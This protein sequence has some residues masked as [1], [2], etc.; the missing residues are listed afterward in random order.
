VSWTLIELPRAEGEGV[1]VPAVG[2]PRRQEQERVGVDSDDR[3][4]TVLAVGLE[5]E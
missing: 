4:R 5:P 2:A 3:E 1:V